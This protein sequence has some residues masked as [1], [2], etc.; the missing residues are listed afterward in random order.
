M[1]TYRDL[2]GDSGIDAYESGADWIAI[3]FKRGGTYVYDS[4]T[5]GLLHVTRMKELALAGDGLG[6]YINQQVRGAYARHER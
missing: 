3:R 1:K 2:S 6:T 4:I 5:P